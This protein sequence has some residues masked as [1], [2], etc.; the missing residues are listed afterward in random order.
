MKT[1]LKFLTSFTKTAKKTFS[2]KMINTFNSPVVT[3]HFNIHIKR[4]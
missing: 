2:I 1:N 3:E 4:L